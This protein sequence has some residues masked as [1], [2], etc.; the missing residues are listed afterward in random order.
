MV[1]SVFK[2]CHLPILLS[3]ET[4]SCVQ[5]C[6]NFSSK[7]LVSVQIYSSILLNNIV[8]FFSIHFPKFF[9][10]AVCITCL[11]KTKHIEPFPLLFLYI[12][13]FSAVTFFFLKNNTSFILIYYLLDFETKEKKRNKKEKKK[14]HGE[15]FHFIFTHQAFYF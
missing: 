15:N 8:G 3:E 9:S 1:I 5:S 13:F 10:F 12:L 4:R 11:D 2:N 6:C 14:I 7:V